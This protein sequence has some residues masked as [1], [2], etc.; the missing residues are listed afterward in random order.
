MRTSEAYLERGG[1]SFDLRKARSDYPSL[2]QF[3]QLQGHSANDIENFMRENKA[4][5]QISHNSD[6]W[7]L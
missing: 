1:E 5:M 4:T 7:K 3:L 6:L 2:K